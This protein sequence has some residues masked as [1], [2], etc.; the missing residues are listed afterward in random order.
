MA[1]SDHRIKEHRLVMAKHLKRC[2]LSWEIVHHKNRIRDDNRIEN[3]ELWDR[4]H[5][6]GVRLS[7]VYELFKDLEKRIEALEGRA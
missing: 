4:S 5:P 7:D 2:L 3:L 1:G 6:N